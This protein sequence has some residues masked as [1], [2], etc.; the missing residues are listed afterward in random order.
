MENNKSNT[1]ENELNAEYLLTMFNEFW[2]SP[3]EGS[4]MIAVKDI[5]PIVVSNALILNHIKKN[6]DIGNY[7]NE[8][9][10]FKHFVCTLVDNNTKE[11]IENEWKNKRK[12]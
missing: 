8:Y 2:S 10:V 5:K 7:R 4:I 11:E 3:Q 9:E 1:K 6:I 12:N